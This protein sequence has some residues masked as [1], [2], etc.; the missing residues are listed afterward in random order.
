MSVREREYS[1]A[2]AYLQVMRPPNLVTAAADVVAGYA[3][4]GQV[5]SWSLGPLVCSGVALYAGGVV[6]NDYF[7]RHVDE[8][9]R[10]ERPIPSGRIPASRV[11]G[12][13]VSLLV[14][15]VLAAFGAS[16]GSGI[17]AVSIA[18]CAWLYDGWAKRLQVV[19]PLL[20]GVCRGL[21]LLLG[22]SAVPA[23]CGDWWF[24]AL[25]PVGYV[26]GITVMSRGEVTGGSRMTVLL[27]FATFG[28]VF[29][30]FLVLG[31]AAEFQLR[32]AGL[33]LM[34]L[35]YRILPAMW[36][37]WNIPDAA[38]LRMAV[39]SGVLSLIVLDAAIAAGFA[40]P[41]YGIAV[42]ALLAVA[43]WLARSFAVT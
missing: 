11:A 20:M 32:W 13:G 39:R 9:E 40:G 16:V 12:M 25:L 6:L 24:L 14:L 2:R 21:N 26:A 1:T 18:V 3:V 7:D 43:A 15:G 41:G 22:V 31:L 10:P 35:G 42:V 30:A 28:A 4:A 36:R 38:N 27:A 29:G 8:V 19:G 37:A 17:L 23:A 34:F 33:F 5:L